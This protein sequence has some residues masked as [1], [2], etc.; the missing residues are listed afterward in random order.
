MKESKNYLLNVD[1]LADEILNMS[2][3]L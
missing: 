2:K 3:I 1:T